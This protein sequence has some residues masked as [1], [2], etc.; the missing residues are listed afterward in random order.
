MI[1]ILNSISIALSVQ[2][3]IEHFGSNLLDRRSN[4]QEHA[5][6]VHLMAQIDRGRV[7]AI[8]LSMLNLLAIAIKIP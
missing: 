7:S 2:A 1:E 3:K 8:A 4:I 6:S 5:A